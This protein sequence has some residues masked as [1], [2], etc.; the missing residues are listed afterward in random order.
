MTCW[1]S[2]VVITRLFM[3]TNR[4]FIADPVGLPHIVMVPRR[5]N[6]TN[7]EVRE[8][9]RRAVVHQIP[10]G[11]TLNSEDL[12]LVIMDAEGRYCAKHGYMGISPLFLCPPTHIDMYG[13]I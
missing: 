13:M 2:I 10:T 9:A 12:K 4:E 1:L 3:T 6:L 7:R 8:L 5:G 11:A